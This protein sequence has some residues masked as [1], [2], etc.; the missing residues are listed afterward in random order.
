MGHNWPQSIDSISSSFPDGRKAGETK[1]LDLDDMVKAV[2]GPIKGS[3]TSSTRWVETS[4]YPRPV[5]IFKENCQQ[6]SQRQAS[7]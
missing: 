4:R 5:G 1:E 6:S 2:R 3:V 7:S